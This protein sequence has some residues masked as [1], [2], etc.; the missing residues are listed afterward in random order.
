MRMKILLFLFFTI[1]WLTNGQT[2]NAGDIVANP[3][4]LTITAKKAIGYD[5]LIPIEVDFVNTTNAD[6]T[7]KVNIQI[8]N[9]IAPSISQFSL[10]DFNQIKIIN[11]SQDI[12]VGKNK[13]VKAPNTFLLFIDRN[14]V[15]KFDKIVHLEIKEGGNL[16]C[17]IKITIQPEDVVLSLDDYLEEDK[18]PKNRINRL[19]YVTRVESTTNNNILTIY[20]YKEEVAND[21]SKQDVFS[22]RS[23]EL[24]RRKAFAINEWSWVF[25]SFHWKPVPISLITVPFKIRPGV[26]FN[27][28]NYSSSA[29]SGLSNVG[30]N[31]D[32]GRIQMDRYFTIGKK[33]THKFSIGFLASPSVEELDATNTNNF[34]NYT[35]STKSKQLFISTG[36]TVSYSYNDLSFVVVP[37]GWDLPTSNLGKNWMYGGKR[38]WGF[39]IA[40]SPKIFSTILNK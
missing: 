12:L 18:D 31:L 35:N 21:G 22:K 8:D 26:N 20:G 19:D 28:N 10:P 38:W 16:L 40:I 17:K 6:L 14:V 7:P 1:S 25:N 36:L 34:T 30:F 9:L 24:K 5:L 3:K 29:T 4:S 23:V 37:A 13:I 11:N 33:S 39:G 15:V 2:I 32:L 27:G